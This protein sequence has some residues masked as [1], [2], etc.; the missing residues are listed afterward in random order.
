VALAAFIVICLIAAIYAWGAHHVGSKQGGPKSREMS[1]IPHFHLT[2]ASW[3]LEEVAFPEPPKSVPPKQKEACPSFHR[4]IDEDA[5]P[6]F[7]FFPGSRTTDT[8]RRTDSDAS[9]H[10]RSRAYISVVETAICTKYL[11]AMY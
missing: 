9:Q 7:F 10:F 1:I 5:S 6:L 4:T 11:R 3:G 8:V 2:R